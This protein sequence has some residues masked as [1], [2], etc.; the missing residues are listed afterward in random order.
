MLRYPCVVLLGSSSW[1]L[2]ALRPVREVSSAFMTPAMT[3]A[4]ASWTAVHNS[5]LARYRLIYSPVR[6]MASAAP[7]ATASVWLF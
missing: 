6:L 2:L 1:Q 5:C 3:R 7:F 4:C